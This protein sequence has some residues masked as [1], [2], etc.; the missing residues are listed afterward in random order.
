MYC[1]VS[2]RTQSHSFSGYEES[3]FCLTIER[4]EKKGSKL[5]IKASKLMIK[6]TK[7]MIKTTK[8]VQS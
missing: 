5:T 2:L 6:T 4:V 3:K 8:Y 7:L 1:A